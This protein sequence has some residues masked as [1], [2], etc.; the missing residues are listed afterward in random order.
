MS[1]ARA[2]LRRIKSVEKT[3]Q[4]TKTMEMVATAKIKKAQARIEA[5]RPY[6][7]KMVEVLH[8]VAKHVGSDSHPLLEVHDPIENVVIV[9]ITSNRGLCG[10]FNM[11][12]LRQSEALYRQETENGRN[13]SFLSVG[14]KGTGYLK[15]VGRNLIAAHTDFSDNPTFLEAKIVADK[16]IEMYQERTLDKVYI[17]FNHFKSVMEQKP[18]V[19]QLLPIKQE[20]ITG[21]EEGADKKN[22]SEYEFEPDAVRV[23]Y[24]LLPRY[25]ETVVLRALME[26]AASE[27]A[28]RRV[29]MKNATDAALEMIESLTRWYNR[30]RQAQITQEIAEIVGG[31]N[32]LQE[33]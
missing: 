24:D 25:V 11:N 19:H 10:A 29:A 30:A 9:P 16:L 21:E 31:A 8:S 15:F 28:A 14:R 32:A 17:V 2:V 27:H 23:L 26:S 1:K 6:A 33:A 4:I 13:V 12:I 7:I 18:T 3:S 22:S 5:A 20:E